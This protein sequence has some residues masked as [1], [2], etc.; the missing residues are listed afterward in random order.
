MLSNFDKDV[1][2]MAAGKPH[3]ITSWGAAVSESLSFL[4]GR[5]LLK[6]DGCRYTITEKGMEQIK[7]S[8]DDEV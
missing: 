6:Q 8:K 1:L 2:R 4:R 7:E 3:S 5:G